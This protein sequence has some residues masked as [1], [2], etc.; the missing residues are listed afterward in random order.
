MGDRSDWEQ[1]LEIEPSPERR[2]LWEGRSEQLAWVARGFQ[3]NTEEQTAGVVCL[4]SHCWDP[5]QRD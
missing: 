2:Q 3:P 5:A 1:V 4:A